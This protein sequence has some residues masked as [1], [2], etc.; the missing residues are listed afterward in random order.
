[1]T[2][3]GW[4]WKL[5]NKHQARTLCSKLLSIDSFQLFKNPDFSQ[6]KVEP[7]AI[8]A[9]LHNDGLHVTYRKRKEHS[10]TIPVE[11]QTCNFGGFR[12]FF[13]CPLCKCRMRMLYLTDKSIFLCRQCLNLSY[14]S[15]LL[16]PTLRYTHMD[17]K[18]TKIIENQGGDTSWTKPKG[19]HAKTYDRL[20]NLQHYYEQKAHQAMNAELRTWYG[21]KIEPYLDGYF[22]YAPEKPS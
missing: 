4:F 12:S 6:F 15:Q 2:H 9:E 21:N 20:K 11:K 22:D 8:N 16:R 5:K 1:M 19:M 13:Q 7:I 17:K 14:E 10:Y 18:I 3:W